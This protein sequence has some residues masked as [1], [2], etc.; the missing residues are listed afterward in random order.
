MPAFLMHASN[1]IEAIR[2]LSQDERRAVWA[3]K[4]FGLGLHRQPQKP[5]IRVVTV[6]APLTNP[7]E[8]K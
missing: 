7:E 8:K 6:P 2:P 4:F 1:S 3:F 5:R